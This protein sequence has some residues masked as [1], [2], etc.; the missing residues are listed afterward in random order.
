M[1]VNCAEVT[2]H[3]INYIHIPKSLDKHIMDYIVC[4]SLWMRS[5]FRMLLCYQNP[6]F[7]LFHFTS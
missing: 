2:R 6:S 7:P 3:W 1:T 5:V 4:T